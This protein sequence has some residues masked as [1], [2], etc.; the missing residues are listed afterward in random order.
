MR[1]LILILSLLSLAAAAGAV[2]GDSLWSH[3][4][5]GNEVDHFNQVIPAGDGNFLL[6]GG[7]S[8]F[9]AG[10]ED[11]WLVKVALNGDSIWSRTFGGSGREFAMDIIPSNDGGFLLVGVTESFSSGL[12]DMWL[13]KTTSNG[14]SIWSRTYGGS[15]YEM[16]FDIVP[17]NDGGF[18]LVGRTNS[19]G[20]GSY[21][22]YVVRINAQGDALWTCTYG[23]IDFDEACSA[24][25]LINGEYL[26]AGRTS[27]FGP[28]GS[29]MYLIRINDLG[30]LLE[31]K[32]Y[33]T[34]NSDWANSIIP[35]GDGGYLLAGE[36]RTYVGYPY[37]YTD[38]YLVKVN[39]HLDE[40][41]SLIYGEWSQ[42]SEK[43]YSIVL[44]G[45]GGFYVVG[46][47]NSYFTPSVYF[48]KVNGLGNVIWDYTF[49]EGF[50]NSIINT[51][52]GNFLLAGY[53]DNLN[54]AYIICVEGPDL[55]VGPTSDFH[56]SSFILLPCFPNPFNPS[57]TIS[58]ELPVSSFVNLKVYDTTG[59]LVANL[60]NG[61][62]EPGMH[63]VIFDGSNL[64]S[65][66]YL[67]RLQAGEHVA[68]RKLILL[69]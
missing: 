12:W 13:V 10:D 8:S 43:A 25:S 29:N 38:I 28:S 15:G 19:F 9:G 54:D 30:N 64:A 68:M 17:S 47:R 51:G 50:A 31:T 24:I 41:W 35:S 48:V 6:V 26:L 69:K 37:S 16:A 52:D 5:G 57:T 33:G 65:G 60:V 58:Y 67:T 44:S 2:E 62:R 27:S 18:L 63:Q 61:W 32:T 34:S 3:A 11:M 59:R 4:Y 66:L 22:M 7:T 49:G 20:A 1:H 14:D 55:G 23:G 39:A 53:E 56:P 42:V 40:L 36:S 21:D 46:E 45:D